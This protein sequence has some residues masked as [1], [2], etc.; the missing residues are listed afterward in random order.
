MYR[1]NLLLDVNI[2][3]GIPMSKTIHYLTRQSENCRINFR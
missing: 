1:K 2:H 3:D